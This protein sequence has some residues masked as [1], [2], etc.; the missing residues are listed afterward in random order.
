[1]RYYLFHNKDGDGFVVCDVE[2]RECGICRLVAAFGKLE[3][4]Q[5]VTA[6]LNDS[7][8]WADPLPYSLYNSV[9]MDYVREN[10]GQ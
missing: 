3:H 8:V 1:M 4:G 7:D 10:L 6:L 2:Q 9:S 5:H